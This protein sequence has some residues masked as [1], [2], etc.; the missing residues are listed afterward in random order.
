MTRREE[1]ELLATLVFE[2]PFY[3]EDEYPTLYESEQSMRDFES[4][5]A[6]KCFEG[7]ILNL[8]DIDTKISECAISWKLSRLSKITLALFRV[9]VYEMLYAELPYTIAINEA[10]E[11]A[12]KYDDDKAPG[13]V[14]G[15]L[16]KIA[17]KNNLK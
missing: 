16:N 4:D 1:R 2:L 10:V 11:L 13:F 7:I 12:K 8:R 3:N 5:Y 6:E 14:N 15:V 9:A 17:E